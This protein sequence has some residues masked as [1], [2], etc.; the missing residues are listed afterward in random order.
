MKK[1]TLIGAMCSRRIEPYPFDP[2][3]T[4]QASKLLEQQRSGR[5]LLRAEIQAVNFVFP[6]A[7][8]TVIGLTCADTG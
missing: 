3:P 8:L 5:R 4:A 2:V 6:L 1:N 7:V